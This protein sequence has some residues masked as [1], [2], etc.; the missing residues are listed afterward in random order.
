MWKK[1]K[2]A[3]NPEGPGRHKFGISF[4]VTDLSD[5]LT[6]KTVVNFVETWKTNWE[7]NQIMFS[8]LVGM[9]KI[10]EMDSYDGID[11]K[12]LFL[13]GGFF[14]F[15]CDSRR[16]ILC[17]LP[18]KKKKKPVYFMTNPTRWVWIWPDDFNAN[19]DIADILTVVLICRS[20]RSISIILY[21]YWLWNRN[22]RFHNQ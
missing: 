19:A 14:S 6:A 16:L 8:A 4:L 1:R 17:T 9:L 13:Q 12:M 7:M 5:K 15:A 10:R 3:V 2:K 11:T 22:K 18:Y 20:F 21:F